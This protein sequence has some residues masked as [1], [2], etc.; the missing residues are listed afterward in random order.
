MRFFI[1]VSI[2]EIYTDDRFAMMSRIY[3]SLE[4]SVYASYDVGKFDERNVHFSAGK[5]L[6][7]LGRAERVTVMSWC[8]SNSTRT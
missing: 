4:A 6:G 2:F 3:P 1:D 5:G 8:N 7:K